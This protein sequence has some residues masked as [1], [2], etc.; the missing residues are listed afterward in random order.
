MSTD[1]NDT[2]KVTATA[3]LGELPTPT[4]ATLAA[5]M[6]ARERQMEIIAIRKQLLLAGGDVAPEVLR[7]GL[8]LIRADRNE[9][10]GRKPGGGG[11]S[12]K[13]KLQPLDLSDF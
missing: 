3:T 5:S 10:T 13:P 1:M 6:P 9:R 4:S 12:A 8:E 7:R 11:R 2:L